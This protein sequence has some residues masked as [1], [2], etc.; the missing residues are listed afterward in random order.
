[1]KTQSNIIKLALTCITALGLL[2]TTAD[3]AASSS[4]I[5]IIENDPGNSYAGGRIDMT[6]STN[7]VTALVRIA[8]LPPVAV[9]GP[10]PTVSG[11]VKSGILTSSSP[12][13]VPPLTVNYEIDV[14]SSSSTYNRFLGGNGSNCFVSRG[15]HLGYFAGWKKTTPP[16]SAKGLHNFVLPDPSTFLGTSWGSYTVGTTGAY[17]IVGRT[18]TDEAFTCAASIGP[19]GFAQN[20]AL[21]SMQPSNSSLCGFIF[22]DYLSGPQNYH[23]QSTVLWNRPA[24][25][26]TAPTLY[27]L[28]FVNLPLNVDGGRYTPTTFVLANFISAHSSNSFKAPLNFTIAG[29]PVATATNPDRDIDGTHASPSTPAAYKLTASGGVFTA[30]GHLISSPALTSLK[31]NYTTGKSLSGSKFTL[32]DPHT[33]TPPFYGNATRV[34]NYSGIAY[35]T[36]NNGTAGVAFDGFFL[37]PQ[38][39]TSLTAAPLV[40]SGAVTLR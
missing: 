12:L 10:A 18:A 21:F 29:S 20:I 34:V 31:F 25:V 3:A 28:G 37:L 26:L 36:P 2:S 9:K 32:V 23:S 7:A 39:P 27:P 17:T 8:H 24:L 40:D 35:P 30:P 15:G 13:V 19:D 11:G 38:I 5:A 6:E 1:M 22:M 33:T 4:Y 16:A 14:N